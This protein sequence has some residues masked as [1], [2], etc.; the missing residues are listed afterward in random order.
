[1]LMWLSSRAR[2]V[3][4]TSVL[5]ARAECS[6]LR[7]RSPSLAATTGNVSPVRNVNIRWIRPILPMVQIMTSTVFTATNTSTV[8]HLIKMNLHVRL[9]YLPFVGKKAKTKSMPLDT[10]SIAGNGDL[11]SCPRCTGKVFAAEKMVAASGY[12]HRHCF[13]CVLCSQPLDSTSVCDGPDDKIYCRVCYKRLRGSS[14]PKFF[15]EANVA[16]HTIGSKDGEKA[17]PRCAGTVCITHQGWWRN[18]N[19]V[20]AGA[21]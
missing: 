1:M 12:Y 4:W 7:S 11:G 9:Y 14:K 2:M 6:R 5:A 20:T 10:T 3:T 19:G 16:T 13:R 17:C 21:K 18:F 8:K 15:D